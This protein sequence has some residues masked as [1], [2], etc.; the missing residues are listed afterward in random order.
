MKKEICF[1]NAVQ[2]WKWATAI[3][4]T[5]FHA[6]TRRLCGVNKIKQTRENHDMAYFV[7][8]ETQTY[9]VN[10]EQN[11]GNAFLSISQQKLVKEALDWGSWPLKVS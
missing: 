3:Y 8:H 1:V 5:L 11:W 2:N 9:D 4:N 10:V 6:I 7:E